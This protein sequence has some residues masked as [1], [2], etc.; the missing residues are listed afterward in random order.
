M[1]TRIKLRR[2]TSANWAANNPILALGEPGLDTTVNK[3]KYGDGVTRWNSLSYSAGEGGTGTYVLV[4]ATNSTLGGVKIGSGIAITADGTI[5]VSTGGGGT[6]ADIGDFTFTGSQV[7]STVTMTVLVDNGNTVFSNPFGSA[8]FGT[9]GGA[10]AINGNTGTIIMPDNGRI[11]G[12]S[13][14][15]F[16][17]SGVNSI[18]FEDGSTL[19]SSDVG[20]STSTLVNGTGTVVLGSTGTLVLSNNLELPQRNLQTN[21]NAT[22]TNI[23]GIHVVIAAGD[24]PVPQAGWKYNGYTIASVTGLSGN[25]QLNFD[26]S[27]P[28]TTGTYVLQAYPGSLPAVIKFSDGTVQTTAYTGEVGTGTIDL[29]AVSQHI[30]PST[31]V[32]YDLGAS[33]KQWRSLYVSSSTIY[34]GGKAVSINT[35]NQITVDGTPAIGGTSTVVST[36]PTDDYSWTPPLGNP[37]RIVTYT[38]T[39]A[40]SYTQDI[41]SNTTS[42]TSTNTGTNLTEIQISRLSYPDIDLI[43]PAYNMISIDGLEITDFISG[44]RLDRYPD[45]AVINLSTGMSVNISSSSTILI[46]YTTTGS[47]DVLWFDFTDTPA[48]GANLLGGEIKYQATVEMNDGNGITVGKSGTLNFNNAAGQ[49]DQTGFVFG[50]STGTAVCNFTEY[51]SSTGFSY[52]TNLGLGEVDRV[53]V[54]WKATLFYNGTW[55]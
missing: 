6:S 45:D 7:S 8:I 13:G 10:V 40:A 29:S 41:T 25:Y 5:S 52:N 44:I 17:L 28:F 18:T 21:Y 55:F 54:M 51:S 14:N 11:Q 22:A 46:Q 27:L 53:K 32:I 2:D 49:F 39:F 48:A 26:V 24:Y 23:D 47:G 9:S 30:I 4:T 50:P 42:T 20:I 38:G 19:S 15:T 33:D 35:S 16:S 43:L 37:W 31:D 3:V 12:T 36:S 1:T 34:I